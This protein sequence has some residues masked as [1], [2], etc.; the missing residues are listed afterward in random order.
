MKDITRRCSFKIWSLAKLKEVGA[1]QDQL[2]S[3]YV[4]YVLSTAEFGAQVYAPLS[5]AAQS[6]MVESIQKRCLQII[7]S[8]A[9]SS[10]SRNLELLGLE[11]LEKRRERIL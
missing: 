1:N 7:L 4:A 8:P 6:Y 2:V 10:Y 5:N 9:S 3:L 11:I